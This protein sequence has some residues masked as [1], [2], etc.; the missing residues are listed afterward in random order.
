M[1]GIVRVVVSVSD[2][3]TD[4]K[5]LTE[6]EVVLLN[7]SHGC[8]VGAESLTLFLLFIPR[9]KASYDLRQCFDVSTPTYDPCLVACSCSR[10]VRPSFFAQRLCFAYGALLNRR[11]I[12][13]VNSCHTRK[14]TDKWPLAGTGCCFP[15]CQALRPEDHAVGRCWLA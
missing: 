13:A 8:Q 4:V 9:C 7:V 10:K 2:N 15:G 5:Q 11:T 12:W 6:D 14:F 3:S 1:N